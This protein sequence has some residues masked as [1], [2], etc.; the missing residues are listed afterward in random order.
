MAIDGKLRNRGMS[1]LHKLKRL[2][3]DMM[4]IWWRLFVAA[5]GVQLNDR[6]FDYKL[7]GYSF[8]EVPWLYRYQFSSVAQS[9]LT[10]CSPMD[11]STPGF[12]VLHQLPELA[13]THVH[14]VGDAIQSLH[15]LSSPSP[16]AFSLS[17]HQGLFQ[18]V[19][20][21]YQV[22]EVLELQLQ[23]QSFQWMFRTDLL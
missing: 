6:A 1:I 9:C 2:I 14:R 11:C 12:F 10:L 8:T 5:V 15:P 3:V 17:Q 7:D 20:S 19:R 18:W 21:S 13:Q 16:P 4:W 23:H 22:A